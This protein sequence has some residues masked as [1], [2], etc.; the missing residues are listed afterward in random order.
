MYYHTTAQVVVGYLLGLVMGYIYW[1]LVL[2]WIHI[3]MIQPALKPQKSNPP[4]VVQ[5]TC[6]KKSLSLYLMMFM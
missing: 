2:P 3:N 4:S 1:G 6:I 5:R